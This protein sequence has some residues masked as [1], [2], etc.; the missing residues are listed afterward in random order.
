DNNNDGKVTKGEIE[1]EMVK[2]VPS[3][4]RKVFMTK[5]LPVGLTVTIVGVAIL[6]YLLI[7]GKNLS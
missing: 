1:D 7:N 4:W 3:E 2:K 5:V 6:S